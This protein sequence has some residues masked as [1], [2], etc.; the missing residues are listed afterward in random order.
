MLQPFA[1][2]AL[3]KETQRNGKRL[4]STMEELNGFYNA[5]VP[6]LED[7]LG[8]LNEFELKNLS[9]EQTNLLYMT[10]SIA[11]I[12]MAV[13]VYKQPQVSKSFQE[14]GGFERFLT[15]HQT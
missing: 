14:Y 9:P 4:A 1:S 2:W 11:D 7:V 3:P 8:Y 12:S 13:E 10:F 15:V 6:L 5:M